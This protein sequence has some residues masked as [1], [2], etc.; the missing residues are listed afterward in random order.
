MTNGTEAITSGVI[1]IRPVF[2]CE[3]GRES[4]PLTHR[5]V[6]PIEREFGG[7]MSNP[8]G[9]LVA[10]PTGRAETTRG[11]IMGTRRR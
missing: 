10:L 6:D 11:T 2:L 8:T 5:N 4:S 3:P 7:E 1:A 9:Q